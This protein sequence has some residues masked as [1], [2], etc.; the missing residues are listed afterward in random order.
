MLIKLLDILDE[1]EPARGRGVR[2]LGLA[3]PAA[4]W[5]APREGG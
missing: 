3:P 5:R 2:W 4:P 1:S